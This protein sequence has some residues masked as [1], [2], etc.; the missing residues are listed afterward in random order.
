MPTAT[1]SN[2]CEDP[3]ENWCDS[4]SYSCSIYVACKKC[5]SDI[6]NNL[7]NLFIYD[8]TYTRYGK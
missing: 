6:P 7:K 8:I 4:V 3:L 5:Y 1:K 2:G